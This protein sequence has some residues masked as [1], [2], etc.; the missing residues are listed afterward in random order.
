MELISF[1]DD[2]YADNYLHTRLLFDSAEKPD[3]KRGEEKF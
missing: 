1:E 2:A 3:T